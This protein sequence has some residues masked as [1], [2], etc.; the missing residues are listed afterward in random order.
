VA[1]ALSTLPLDQR[2]AIVLVDLQGIAVRD[3]ATLLGVAEGTVKSRCSRGRARLAVLLAPGR[4]A[5]A[6]PPPGARLPG[7]ASGTDLPPAASH[8]RDARS[9]ADTAVEEEE[10]R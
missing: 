10:A 4:T 3:A 1:A 7:Q 8:P 5:G 2:A 9:A 6:L